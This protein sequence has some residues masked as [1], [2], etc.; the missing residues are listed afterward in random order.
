[1]D[2]ASGRFLTLD[3]YSGNLQDPLSLHKYLYTHANPIMGIDPSGL[4]TVGEVFTAVG[5]SLNLTSLLFN[6]KATGDAIARGD[7]EAAY[8][9]WMWAMFDALFLVIPGFTLFS[10]GSRAAASVGGGAVGLTNN[11]RQAG[12]TTSATWGYTARIARALA[13]VEYSF[14]KSTSSA[15]DSGPRGFSNPDFGTEVHRRFESEL[16]KQTGTLI[17]DWRM[18]TGPHQ[19][20]VDA[21]YIGPLS[22]DP[23]FK[24]AELKPLTRHSFMEFLKQLDKWQFPTGQTQLWFYNE[25][26]VIG[27]TGYNY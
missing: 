17:G 15:G 2:P 12:V 27:T 23:G 20:G 19:T 5:I 14:S 10:G 13:D 11:L 1:M 26:G 22:R 24:Y 7:T 18:R 16:I 9:N 8:E 21:Q 4:F 3:P 6:V 25:Q